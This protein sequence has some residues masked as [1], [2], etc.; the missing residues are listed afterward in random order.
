MPVGGPGTPEHRRRRQEIMSVGHT[1]PDGTGGGRNVVGAVGEV[2]GG[3]PA[4]ATG[5]GRSSMVDWDGLE[6]T[7]RFPAA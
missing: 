1:L 7:N 4:P 2:G 3:G 6:K 5:G